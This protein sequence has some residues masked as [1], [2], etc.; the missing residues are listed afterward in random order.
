MSLGWYLNRALYRAI[1][2]TAAVW[3]LAV[4]GLA[5]RLAS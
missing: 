5:D 4:T 3:L 2:L 1:L